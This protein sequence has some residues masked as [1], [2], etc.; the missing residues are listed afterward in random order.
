MDRPIFV[1][2]QPRSGSTLLQRLLNSLENVIIYGEHLGLL[3]G[4][5]DSYIGFLKDPKRREF[6]SDTVDV[7]AFRTETVNRLKDPLHFSAITNGL[8]GDEFDDTYRHFIK[9]LLH[10]AP[11]SDTRRW[12]FKE[13]RYG[14][15][16]VVFEMLLKLFPAASFVFLVRHPLHSLESIEGTGWWKTS[17]D[18]NLQGWFA[19][20]SNYLNY[21][22]QF[23]KHSFFVKYEDLTNP[24]TQTASELFKWLG[25]KFTSTQEHLL[26]NAG[27]IGAAKEKIVFSEDHRKKI[28]E[29]SRRPEVSALYPE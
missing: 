12:G 3:K 23:P 15:G 20:A 5:A 10:G 1:F 21:H 19:Q 28:F 17:F 18:E 13:I 26:H 9:T 11:A 4:V 24:G 29:V 8:V 2:A 25:Y 22:R 6:C 27:K 16:D 7:E 14:V